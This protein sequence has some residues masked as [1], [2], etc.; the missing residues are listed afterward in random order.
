LRFYDSLKLR[1]VD[2]GKVET[3]PKAKAARRSYFS[4][5]DLATIA[6][7]GALQFVLQYFAGNIN[8]IPGDERNIVAFPVGFMAAITYLRTKK[9]GAVGATTLIAGIIQTLNTGFLPVIFEWVGAT[10]GFEAVIIGAHLTRGKARTWA[11][12][13]GASCLMLGRAIGVTIGLLIFFPQ[14]VL[15]NFTTQELA[16]VYITFNAVTPF[17]IAAIGA[18]AAIRLFLKMGLVQKSVLQ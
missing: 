8:F 5:S 11:I 17:I 12:C 10:I 1:A 3:P 7:F 16:A 6:I 14:F 4:T 15:G 18:Y 2:G 9:I 13:L